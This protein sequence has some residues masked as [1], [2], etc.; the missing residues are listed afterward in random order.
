MLV[1]GMSKLLPSDSAAATAAVSA[2]IAA[3]GT[4]ETA[5][6]FYGC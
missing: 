3:A 1:F 5:Y 2:T 6:C 4:A